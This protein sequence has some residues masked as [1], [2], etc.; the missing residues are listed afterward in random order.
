M[1]D[2]PEACAGPLVW[3][4]VDPRPDHDEPA[5]AVLECGTCGYVVSTGNFL[6]ERH[7]GTPLLRSPA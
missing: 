5:G 3:F 2:Q 4:D 1:A 6:D 7:S